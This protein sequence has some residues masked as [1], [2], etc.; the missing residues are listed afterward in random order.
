MQCLSN[1][2]PLTEY[3]LND[4]YQEELNFDNPLG[5]RGEI[6]KSYAELIKQMWS[7]KFSY[8]TPRAFKVSIINTFSTRPVSPSRGQ[9]IWERGKKI[10]A[11]TVVYDPLKGHDT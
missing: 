2:P 9:N 5:M 4:K 8:V 7:G 10:I 6:A 11:V 1:T 3:F